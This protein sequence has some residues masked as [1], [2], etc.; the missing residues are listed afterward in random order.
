MRLRQIYG[1][2]SIYIES[3][4]TLDS[5][6]LRSL[7]TRSIFIL[8]APIL[9]NINMIFKKCQVFRHNFPTKQV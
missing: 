7:V 5:R 2:F 6:V 3:K 9:S 8:D 1:I 4:E